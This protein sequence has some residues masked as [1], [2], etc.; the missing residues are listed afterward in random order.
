M[1][2]CV[3]AKKSKHDGTT[4]IRNIRTPRIPSRGKHPADNNAPGLSRKKSIPQPGLSRK[5][6]IPQGAFRRSQ[7]ASEMKTFVIVITI[8]RPL[9][10]RIPVLILARRRNHITLFP[11]R[12]RGALL[13]RERV[14]LLRHTGGEPTSSRVSENTTFS[15][16]STFAAGTGALSGTT[17]GSRA[18]PK[19]GA[20][21]GLTVQTPRPGWQIFPTVPNGGR[22]P[23]L[24]KGMAARSRHQGHI[25]GL[26]IFPRH[27][28]TCHN[29]TP[30]CVRPCRHRTHIIFTGKKFPQRARH[31]ATVQ[32]PKVCNLA[33]VAPQSWHRAKK[34]HNAKNTLPQSLATVPIAGGA[35]V[36]RSK[37]NKS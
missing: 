37:G 2:F 15:V 35:T 7:T 3:S 21:S 9:G 31:L 26:K 22:W 4:N 32:P 36:A 17:G 28:T 16:G 11:C 18:R 20:A 6:S 5:K 25:Y 33:T 34:F 23:N 29:P 1:K 13:R 19:R 24:G 12:S 10:G 8:T 27:P 30:S 14:H